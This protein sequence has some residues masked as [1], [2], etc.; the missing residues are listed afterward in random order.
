MRRI[1][2]SKPFSVFGNQ[3]RQRKVYTTPTD[4]VKEQWFKIRGMNEKKFRPEDDSKP[5]AW[6]EVAKSE[7]T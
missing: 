2:I 3:T 5:D 1:N 7:D 6:K 4:F